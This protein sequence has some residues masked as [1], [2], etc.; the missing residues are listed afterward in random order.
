[1]A[2]YSFEEQMYFDLAEINSRSKSLSSTGGGGG[3]IKFAWSR[4][5]R[6]YAP[7]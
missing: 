5:H 4:V 1:M 2:I 3:G 7:V 6:G